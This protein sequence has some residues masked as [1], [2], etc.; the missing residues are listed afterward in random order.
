MIVAIVS[1][2]PYRFL[3]EES[4]QTLDILEKNYEIYKNDLQKKNSLNPED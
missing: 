1:T 3:V 4:I 2:L